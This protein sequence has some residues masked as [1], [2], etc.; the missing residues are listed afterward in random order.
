MAVRFR[1][2][3]KLAPGVRM[4]LSGSGVGWSLGPRG[5]SI[6]IGKKGTY[7]N[8]G[9]PGTG[10]SARQKISGG[11]SPRMRSSAPATTSLSVAIGVH[12]DGTLYFKDASGQH[13]PDQLVDAAKK[14][15]GESIRKLIQDKCDEINEQI[16][17]VGELHVDT[18]PP[19]KKPFYTPRQFDLERPISPIPKRPNFFGSLFKS[20]RAKVEAENYQALQHYDASLAS[21]QDQKKKF[22]EQE[23]G[24]R[25][26]IEHS[27]YSE[28]PAMEA[29]LEDNLQEITWPRETIVSAEIGNG[30]RQV[31]I[32]VDLPEIEDMPNK[33]AAAPVR[34]YK[35]SVKEM[36]GIQL[37]RLYMRHVHSIAFRTIGEAFAALPVADEIVLS[38]FSQRP[39]KAT[40]RISDEYL[41][42]VRVSRRLWSAIDFSNL[43]ELD[44]VEALTRF[45]IRR[46]MTKTGSFK[47]IAPFAPSDVVPN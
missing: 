4:N 31:F 33:T 27:I 18:P 21:W 30:G 42:S 6:G 39:D 28:L 12:D 29:F 44:V 45:E 46:T 16:E 7:L 25:Q 36:S 1:K 2:S 43:K 8:A 11:S 14:Q 24:R 37:Q 19:D 3:F 17:A 15:H 32:D 10:L 40:G 34:G 9:L 23:A 5:A 41:Y 22:E 47:P 35:L 13:L 38:G 26:F 20:M